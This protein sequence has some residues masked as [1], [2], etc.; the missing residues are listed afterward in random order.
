MLGIDVAWDARMTKFNLIYAGNPNTPMVHP[1]SDVEKQSQVHP[2]DGRHEE[3]TKSFS[4]S[5][6]PPSASG[7]DPVL[8]QQNGSRKPMWLNEVE[9][10]WSRGGD[11][12]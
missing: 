7:S 5:F 8:T 11:M 12:E 1:H 3:W 10:R 2:N 4:H 6:R 9:I